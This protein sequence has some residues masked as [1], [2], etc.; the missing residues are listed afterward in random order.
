MAL[1][2]ASKNF[3]LSW[4][5]TFIAGFILVIWGFILILLERRD[6]RRRASQSPEAGPKPAPR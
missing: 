4:V 6:E 2:E 1:D 3:L 5:P